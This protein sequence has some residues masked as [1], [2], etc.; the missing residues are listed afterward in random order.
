MDLVRMLDEI[1][2]LEGTPPIYYLAAWAWAK[3]FGSAEPGLRALSA[4]ASTA[5]VPVAYAAARTV[6]RQPAAL[7]T[8][9]LVALDPLL[10]W[11][12]QEARAYALLALL[13]AF[14]LLFFLRALTGTGRLGPNLVG[15]SAA[16]ALAVATHYFAGLLVVPEAI[17]LLWALPRRPVLA[18]WLAPLATAG[19]LS[20]IV[21]RQADQAGTGEP[22][23]APL[24]LR[25]ARIPKQFLVGF[26][27]PRERVL[28]AAALI[29]V[30]VAVGLM[31]QHPEK[32][33]RATVPAAV[34]LGA[35]VLLLALALIGRDYVLSRY[36][37]V[38]VVPLA[39]AAGA[40]FVASRLGLAAGAVLAAVML[41][42]VLAV[43]FEPRAQRPDYRGALR[44]STEGPR[45]V[46]VSSEGARFEIF[47]PGL[48]PMP[49]SGRKVRELDV[50]GLVV[51]G[52]EVHARP[53]PA[54]FTVPRRSFRLSSVKRTRGYVVLRYRA[55]R[56]TLIS[57]VVF[58]G[59]HP[60]ADPAVMLYEPRRAGQSRDARAAAWGRT[61]S[62]IR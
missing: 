2:R 61:R 26:N 46:V 44:T 10:V 47:R 60:G 1:P 5:T 17:W 62:A 37:V 32:R 29:A 57:P 58:Y 55:S 43:N 50:I 38:L 33:G 12:G 41:A 35:I 16:S 49:S 20:P 56:P 48:R 45:A 11:Y 21:L 19:A 22:G 4:L 8:A 31:A 51:V 42:A 36:L 13:S 28:T 53:R 15:W 9:A 40:G 52:G 6:A 24:D 7:A 34:A 59:R 27:V 18:A 25:L 14:G 3:W 54:L 23:L 39:I 30:A